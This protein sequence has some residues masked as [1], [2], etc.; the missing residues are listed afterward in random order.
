ME[1]CIKD[2]E[3]LTSART[4]I[5]LNCGGIYDMSAYWFAQQE[6]EIKTFIF[7][8]HQPVHH[9]NVNSEKKIYVIDDGMSE[10]ADCPTVQ[11]QMKL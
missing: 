8:N 9:Q 5:F 6:S 2:I 10:L 4:L 7:D 1:Q 3:S 11:D